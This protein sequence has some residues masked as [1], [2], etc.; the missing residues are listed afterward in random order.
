MRIGLDATPLPA[1]P[2][3]AGTYIIQL[4]LALGKLQTEHEFFVFVHRNR[5]ELFDSSSKPGF[6]WIVVSSKSPALRLLWEQ[7]ALPVLARKM[8]L[9]LLHSLHYT[10]P[11]LLPCRSV[12]TFH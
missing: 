3:G 10:R 1:D 7:A 12:V 5:Q 4:I 8:K 6:N 9:D 2:V 11:I